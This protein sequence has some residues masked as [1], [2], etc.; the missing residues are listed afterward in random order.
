MIINEKVTVG[1]VNDIPK[2]LTW[3]GRSHN[4]TQVGLHHHFRT[5]NTLYHIFSVTSETIFMR[6][7]L[8]TDNLSWTLEE[9][10]NEF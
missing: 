10:E 9:I 1:M 6:L 5:G 4:I 7:K 2:Y 3:K 8:D